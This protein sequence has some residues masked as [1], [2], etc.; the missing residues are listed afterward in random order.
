MLLRDRL[1]ALRRQ[2]GLTRRELAEGLDTSVNTLA[3]WLHGKTPPAAI[4]PL[5]D[6]IE[7]DSSVRRRLGLSHGRKQPPPHNNGFKP[8]NPW[9]IGSPTREAALAEARKRKKKPD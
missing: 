4:G 1:D 9:R 6:L 2:R 8:G 7:T 5:L 3:G